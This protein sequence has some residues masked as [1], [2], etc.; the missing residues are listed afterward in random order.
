MEVSNTKSS[1]VWKA[2]NDV[3]R[4]KSNK[5]KIKATSGEERIIVWYNICKDLLC[6][7]PE[8]TVSDIGNY[9]KTYQKLKIV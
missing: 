6:N 2:V 8:I 7:P 5:A 4:K 1:M 9:Q 3:I